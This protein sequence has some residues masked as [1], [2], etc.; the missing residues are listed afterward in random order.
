MTALTDHQFEL[1]PTMSASDGQVFGIGS[2][3]NL[4]ENGFHPGDDDWTVEDDANP[5]KGGTAFG[6]DVLNGPT[7]AWDLF[8]DTADESE[9]LVA[10]S[11]LRTAWRALDLRRTPGGVIPIRYQ[12]DGRVRRIFG[13]PRR[14]SGQPNN[15]ILAGYVPVTVD[16]ACSD[17]YTY[18]DLESST[19]LGIQVGSVGGFI[20]PLTFP[21]GN[22]ARRRRQRPGRGRR[23][24][25]DLPCDHLQRSGDLARAVDP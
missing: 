4:D 3:I 12:L 13:R 20:F 14:F 7:W 18:D 6:R 19:T 25:P 1:L 22:P 11:A 21:L 24:R 5:R 9:A 8:V 23:R 10:L 17:S 2:D 15:Q 16:F